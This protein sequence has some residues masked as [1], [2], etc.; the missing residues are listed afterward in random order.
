V[1][2]DVTGGAR[3]DT[4]RVIRELSAIAAMFAE[5]TDLE[6][7]A[8]PLE[9]VLDRLLTV[10]YDAFYLWDFKEKRLRC[11]FSRGFTDEERRLAEATAMDRHPGRVFR[12]RTILH[13]ADTENDPHH[14][15]KT[16]PGRRLKVRSRL[17]I[18]VTYGEQSL[19]SFGLASPRPNAFTAEHVAVLEFV[20]RLTGVFYR[21]FL[22]REERR[23]TERELA[24]TARR[25]QLVINSLP[26]ALVL[27]DGGG[28]IE[29]AEGAA[30]RLLE[31]TR[32]APRA[33]SSGG[34]V[35][36]P[37]GVVLGD[38]ELA[39]LL[40]PGGESK[41][42]VRLFGERA[43]GIRAFS[44]DDGGATLVLEDIS[45]RQRNLQRLRAL[46]DELRQARDVAVEAT[47]AKSRFLATM[48]HELRTPLNVIIGYGEMLLEDA[49]GGF[50]DT[51]TI[52]TDLER[53]IHSAKHLLMLINDILDI[54]KIEA[55]KF[56]LQ[57][58]R[59]DLPALLDETRAA[60]LPLCRR[61]GNRFTIVAPPALAPIVTDEVALRRVLTNLLSNANKFTEGGEL[62]LEVEDARASA[63][64]LRFFVRDTG[65]GMT[66]DELT[67]IFAA[68][69]QVDTSSTRRF[70][71]TGLG[72]TITRELVE[73]LGGEIE[74]SSTPGVGSTF[75][76]WI[77]ELERREPAARG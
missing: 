65:I 54:S 62:T 6:G 76:F 64:Q 68:F 60:M 58:S 23:E 9:T 2:D 47:R 19:G 5:V 63:G 29:L 49:H 72:L 32:P 38:T 51:E 26:I 69:T 24:S 11:V 33:C 17:F 22:D 77:P 14:R 15:S 55:G 20:C 71:G 37:A 18:P 7:L 12:E 66:A 34:L 43:L 61:S 35:G 74:V 56:M 75:A 42:V 16:S 67:Q 4:L 41:E 31:E 25:L 40:R 73:A 52:D 50:L 27:V 36:A 10:E 48:S 1:E 13:V 3:H 30:L 57:P 8:R 53:I 70:G 59:V 21:Q 44:R 46:N 45:E 28:D 39:G